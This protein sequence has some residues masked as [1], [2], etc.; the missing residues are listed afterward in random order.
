GRRS[1]AVLLAPR[2]TRGGPVTAGSLCIRRHHRKCRQARGCESQT[3]P[4]LEDHDN[5]LRRLDVTPEQRSARLT[6][7]RTATRSGNLHGAGS[8]KPRRRQAASKVLSK[9]QAIVIGPTPPGTGVIAPATALTE[10]K[11]TSPTT[12][13]RPS[14]SAVGVIPTSMTVAPGFTQSAL[15]IR[16]R[17]AAA[18][19]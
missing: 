8:G 18:I 4:S 6:V 1:S 16:G 10:A 3:R 5:R 15:T 17:P 19:R 12:R 9:R 7:P 13:P 11:S 2:A 14:S